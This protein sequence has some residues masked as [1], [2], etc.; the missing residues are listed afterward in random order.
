MSIFLPSLF[1]DTSDIFTHRLSGVAGH[2]HVL[3]Q[4]A[5]Q[6]L[7]R[8]KVGGHNYGCNENSSCYKEKIFVLKNKVKVA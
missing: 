4:V 5:H 1:D 3:A 6:S 2:G 8:G 7:K